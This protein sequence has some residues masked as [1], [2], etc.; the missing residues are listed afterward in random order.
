MLGSDEVAF[1][2]GVRDLILESQERLNLS[3]PLSWRESA[4][5][6][7]SAYDYTQSGH[8]DLEAFSVLFHTVDSLCTP[9]YTCRQFD[10]AGGR[11]PHIDLGCFE[12]WMMLQFSE[13]NN[14]EFAAKATLLLKAVQPPAVLSHWGADSAAPSLL[15]QRLNSLIAQ[16]DLSANTTADR[17]KATAHLKHRGAA[18]PVWKVGCRASI[19]ELIGVVW[20]QTLYDKEQRRTS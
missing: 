13:L 20:L 12:R 19:E 6:I 2:E 16:T 8:I 17:P 14:A 1:E 15:K 7:F 18:P 3:M 11:A 4:G 5:A 9:E 10:T